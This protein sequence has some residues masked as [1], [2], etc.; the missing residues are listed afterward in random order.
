MLALYDQRRPLRS[1]PYPVQAIR[2]GNKLTILALGGEVVVDYALRAKKEYP[3]ERL[4]V[5]GY[6]NDVMCYIPSRRV[7]KEGGYEAET[8]MIY[9]GMPGRFTEDVEEIVFRTIGQ[10]LRRV[11]VKR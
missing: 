1:T 6:S 10:A 3:K 5:A 11:G 4:V 7:L 2:F 9:Y 8:S